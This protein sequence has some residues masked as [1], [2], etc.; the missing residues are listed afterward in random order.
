MSCVT[1]VSTYRNDKDVIT[2]HFSTYLDQVGKDSLVKKQHQQEV[3]D[4]KE[5]VEGVEEGH[6]VWKQ[7]FWFLELKS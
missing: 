5:G 2:L 7:D 6:H 4:T 1:Q 3:Y